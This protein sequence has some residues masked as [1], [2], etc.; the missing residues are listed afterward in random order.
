MNTLS[1]TVFP[2]IAM[3]VFKAIGAIDETQFNVL[4]SDRK[5]LIPVWIKAI[6]NA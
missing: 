3:P 4:M 2:F 6:L 5:S 1:M